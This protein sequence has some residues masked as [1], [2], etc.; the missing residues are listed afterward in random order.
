[1]Q[2]VNLTRR[3]L[4]KSSLATIVIG[5]GATVLSGCQSTSGSRLLYLGSARTPAGSYCVSAAGEDG[6]QR[7]SVPLP[8]RGHGIA[9]DRLGDMAFVFARRP[10]EYIQ[11]FNWQTGQTAPL[12]RAPEDRYFYGHGVVSADGLLYVTEGE[13]KT[14]RGI[15]GVY[16]V[17][18]IG[19]LHK[20]KEFT[21]FGI[22]PHEVVLVDEDTLGI[23]VGGVHTKGREPQ[24]I[25]SMKP[26][27]VLINRHTGRIVERHR[28][29]DHKLSIRHLAVGPNG[30]VLTG[31]QYRGDSSQSVPLVAIYHPENGYHSLKA[32]P[33]QWARFNHYIA[34]IACTEKYIYATSPRGNCFGI[35]SLET[36]ELITLKPLIDASGAVIVEDSVALSSGSGKVVSIDSDNTT[37]YKASDVLWDNHWSAVN[38]I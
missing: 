6:K 25:E 4:I 18:S 21:D 19:E 11:P 32:E 20:L 16:T 12:Y 15:I 7:F 23:G 37:F 27:L 5:S 33:E 35:W 24:N 14:S 30:E 38:L 2:Q 36:G 17:S 34:S 22:G 8:A 3:Q 31:Q 9:I 13:V 28:L 10:G 26:E 29:D 1:M